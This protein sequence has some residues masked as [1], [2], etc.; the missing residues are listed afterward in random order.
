MS[1][2]EPTF[3]VTET[4]Q[5]TY[6][7]SSLTLLKSWTSDIHD[8]ALAAVAS[9]DRTDDNSNHWAIPLASTLKDERNLG[10]TAGTALAAILQDIFKQT[11]MDG[12]AEFLTCLNMHLADHDLK[13]SHR[14]DLRLSSSVNNFSEQENLGV[15][16]QAVIL[17][18]RAEPT[19]RTSN[20]LLAL[21]S[22]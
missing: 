15:K 9:F 5:R 12:I 4:E 7:E 13:V 16:A 1:Q 19:G 2:I 11:G 3:K 20:K 10:G 8:G 6:A 18:L 21:T 22:A 14:E 17:Q